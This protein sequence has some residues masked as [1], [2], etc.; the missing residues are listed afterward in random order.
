MIAN[1]LGYGA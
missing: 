1:M